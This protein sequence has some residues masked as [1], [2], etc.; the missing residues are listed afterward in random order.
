MG[1]DSG[2]NG[3]AGEGLFQ[4]LAGFLWRAH[5]LPQPE[6][7]GTDGELSW[8]DL[9]DVERLPYQVKSRQTIS[10]RSAKVRITLAPSEI[11]GWAGRRALRWG[12]GQVDCLLSETARSILAGS[13]CS[14]WQWFVQTCLDGCGR[15][16]TSME[17][18]QKSTRKLSPRN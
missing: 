12:V 8:H 15:Q 11:R 3:G 14:W 6:G 18:R 2:I 16:R 13:L 5:V 10:V 17:T 1:H 4:F 7:H 9:A